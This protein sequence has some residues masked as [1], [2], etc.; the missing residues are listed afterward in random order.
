MGNKLYI[1]IFSSVVAFILLMPVGLVLAQDRTGSSTP[2]FSDA[3]VTTMIAS[4]IG[5]AVATIITYWV[6]SQAKNSENKWIEKRDT[7]QEAIRE[8][9][10]ARA[11]VK[12]KDAE[13]DKLQEQLRLLSISHTR[14]EY[15][16]EDYRR[17]LRRAGE[18]T[19]GDSGG[20]PKSE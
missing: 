6:S 18:P 11:E 16:I 19:T 13:I 5:P 10:E 12:A 1:F 20:S 4:V 7:I 8:R 14:L 2:P 3:L 15:T 9:N 17:R